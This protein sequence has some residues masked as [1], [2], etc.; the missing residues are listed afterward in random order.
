MERTAF[1]SGEVGG[2]VTSEGQCVLLLHGGPGVCC[3][4]LSELMDEI[5][6]GYRVATFQ[7][8]GLAPSTTDGPF[9]LLTAVADVVGVL[10][11]LKWERA[12]L[13][14]HSW[15]GHLLLHVLACASER[16]LGAL[17]VDPVGAIGDGG[18]EMFGQNLLGRTPEK[19]R[20]RVVELDARAMRGE[21]TMEEALEILRLLWPAYFASPQRVMPFPPWLRMS[22]EANE[23]LLAAAVESLPRLER[24]LGTISVPFGVVSGAASPMPAPEGTVAAIPGAWLDV[25]EGAGHFVWFERPGSV[26]AGLQ[27]LTGP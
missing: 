23:S 24:S 7:Q 17:A 21:G 1:R 9:D 27:R 2:W 16:V 12:W 19:D 6:E 11:A 4:Y 25:V 22:V 3:D 13:V 14:G 18:L 8:R 5:G 10:D 15:G 20:Q 26:L